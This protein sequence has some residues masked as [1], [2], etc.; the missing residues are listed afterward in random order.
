MPY[1]VYMARVNYIKKNP[2][3]IQAFTNAIYR[4]QQWVHSH[5]VEE[6]VTKIKPYFPDTDED[7]LLSVVKRYKEQ[8]TW[9][10]NPVIEKE[11]F[12]KYEE[13]IIMAGELEEKAPFDVLVNNKFAHNAIENIQ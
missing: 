6:I 13:I 1:T 3:I 12:E 4:A 5:N 10:T 7:I 9:D 11:I 2:D 8:G